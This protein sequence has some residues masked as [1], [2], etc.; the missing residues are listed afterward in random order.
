MR[1]KLKIVSRI[2][3]VIILIAAISLLYF[4]MNIKFRYDDSKERK[5]V[6]SSI[7][8]DVITNDADVAQKPVYTSG[9]VTRTPIVKRLN[10]QLIVEH[11]ENKI[12]E[13]VV[14][15]Y[16]KPMM[17]AGQKKEITISFVG[18][19]TFGNYTGQGYA[20]SFNEYL[21]KNGTDYFFKNVKDVFG[22]DDITMLNLEGPLTNHQ[23][24]VDKSYPIRC[25]PQTVD[26][27]SK[28]SVEV[29]NI[30][31]NHTYDCGVSGI[32]ETKDILD[33][34][35]IGYC[36]DGNI[37]RTKIDEI[38]ISFLGYK[39]W[40]VNDKIL[41]TIQ[42]DIAMEKENGSKLI[43]VMFHTGTEGSYD[44]NKIQEQLFRHSID[45]GADIVVSSH[46]HVLQGIELYKGKVIC[47]SLGNFSFGANRNPKDK[48]TFIFQQT[49]KVIGDE[50]I[51]GESKVIPC[52]IS[53][54]KDTN[55][56]Q[57]T[58]LEGNEYDRVLEKIKNCSSKGGKGIFLSE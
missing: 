44:S 56:Y 32:E 52:S 31:N 45:V 18:D 11:I 57:P 50:C 2:L 16:V 58:I 3:A 22:N 5:E 54:S 38:Q 34:N 28:N 30:S 49:F 17:V 53:S 9:L 41:T 46:P 29:V 4:S 26:I 13:K 21:E 15:E 10:E 48:D 36:G 20:S 40:S 43:C 7:S 23:T 19:C 39:E 1:E 51:Y 6:K 55:T 14:E 47:Y 35:N 37:Y 33:K 24:T 12:E 27:L 42:S 25:N 8:V